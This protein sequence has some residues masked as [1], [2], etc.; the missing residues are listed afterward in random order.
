MQKLVIVRGFSANLER[1]PRICGRG[2]LLG[3][4]ELVT[5]VVVLAGFLVTFRDVTIRAFLGLHCKAR[6]HIVKF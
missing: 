5:E 4:T 1:T 2:S 3:P 6:I